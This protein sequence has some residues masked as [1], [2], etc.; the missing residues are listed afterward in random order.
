[1]L[2]VKYLN[3]DFPDFSDCPDKREGDTFLGSMGT[4]K[5][6]NTMRC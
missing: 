6:A 2:F 5:I 1:M 4:R 3:Y